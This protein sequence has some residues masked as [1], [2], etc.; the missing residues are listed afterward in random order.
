MKAFADT[1]SPE[2]GDHDIYFNR[3]IAAS[4]A[5]VRR[6]GDKKPDEVPNR[7]AYEWLSR[8]LN[9][10][11]EGFLESCVPGE[12]S[13]RIAA[14]EFYYERFL[15]LVKKV[16][17]SGVKVQIIYDARQDKG[18]KDKNRDA[19]EEAGLQAPISHERTRPKSYISHN[20][21]IV[22]LDSSGNPISV[23]TGGT[24]FSQGGIYG[25][26]NVAHVVEDPAIAAQFL[27]YWEALKDDPESDA[28]KD[29]VENISPLPQGPPPA[30]TTVLFSPR[31]TDAALTW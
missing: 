31:H 5:Y 24:N 7:K 16:H 21:F 19:V 20:K 11:L 25:H 2:G 29:S 27:T 1:E 17:D 28:L 30:G 23:W 15:K 18:P 13:L 26:S 8:G 9:E 22:K 14:Y 4:Q 10:A 6:F 12:H 3:G